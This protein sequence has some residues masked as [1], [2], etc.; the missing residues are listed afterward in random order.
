MNNWE[1]QLKRRRLWLLVVWLFF[2][3][4]LLFV[5][6]KILKFVSSLPSSRKVFVEKVGLKDT[7]QVNKGNKYYSFRL[8]NSV[9]TLQNEDNIEISVTIDIDFKNISLLDEIKEKK[10]D[11]LI[12][13]QMVITPK[14]KV[15]LVV[16]DIK[17]ELVKEYNKLLS[18]G[19]ISNIRFVDF[20][21]KS[22][23]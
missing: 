5:S 8:G 9:L 3:P 15:E 20:S 2:I 11:L 10:N 1:K 14:R 21:V 19:K 22:K 16:S 13:T 17:E 12:I 23:G 18:K 4:S 6:V 7:L